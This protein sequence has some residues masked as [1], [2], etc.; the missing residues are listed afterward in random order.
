MWFSGESTPLPTH[1]HLDGSQEPR[2]IRTTGWY[3]K[4]PTTPGRTHIG[5]WLHCYH[6]W[7]LHEP[8]HRFGYDDYHGRPKSIGQAP[9]CWNP[10]NTVPTH[11]PKSIFFILTE[12]QRTSI[13]S[14]NMDEN[15]VLVCY[16]NPDQS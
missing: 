16:P 2:S 8:V 13:P 15:K 7:S 6:G 14:D 11:H 3:A 4:L 10:S 12:K 1:S 9:N 5:S